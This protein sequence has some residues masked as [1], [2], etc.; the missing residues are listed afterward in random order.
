[1]Q[2]TSLSAFPIRT[3][4]TTPT[5]VANDDGG[6]DEF[7]ESSPDQDRIAYESA[8]NLGRAV[9]AVVKGAAKSGQALHVMGTGFGL[10]TPGLAGMLGLMGGTYDVTQGASLA[11]KSAVDRNLSGTVA[12]SLQVLQGVAT[13]ASVLGPALGAPAVI[14]Q[15][16]AVVA[17]TTFASRLGLAGFSA[18]STKLSD[19]TDL[20]PAQSGLGSSG[21]ET[22]APVKSAGPTDKPDGVN[23]D[24]RVFENLFAANRSVSQFVSRLGGIGAFWNNVDSLFGGTP[25]G[26]WG[27]LG[28]MGSTN[29]VITGMGTLARGAFNQHRPDTI[30]G[31]LHVV[32]GL[33][34]VGASMG[35]GQPA[36][37]VAVGAFAARMVY[38]IWEQSKQ[39]GDDGGESMLGI[40]KDSALQTVGFGPS[41]DE[42]SA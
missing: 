12:G 1:M 27:F 15:G 36:A 18:I 25:G 41:D 7:Q 35:L 5:A 22:L 32:Q 23:G 8:Y 6:K 20:M 2:V 14:G 30:N 9:N 29:S 24:S 19:K 42:K 3:A 40:V 37:I 33:G 13:Y 26:V 10:K 28:I 11:Q 34:S 4:A 21:V 17:A 39:L 38:T 16:A 31:A